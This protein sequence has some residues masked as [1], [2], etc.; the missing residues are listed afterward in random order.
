MQEVEIP[1]YVNDM[2]SF[3]MWEIDEFSL[4]IGFII[5]GYL[6]GGLWLLAFLAAGLYAASK[7]KKWK[8]REL[9]GV[10]PHVLFSR[11]FTSLNSI[12]KNA[13]HD[14]LWI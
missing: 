14:D 4:M 5:I 3:F 6:M 12:Y 8:R 2:P 7:L 11:G 13:F 10:I 9:D 1:A